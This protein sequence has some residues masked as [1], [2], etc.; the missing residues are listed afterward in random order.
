VTWTDPS[1]Q[2]A[3]ITSSTHQI[4]PA[5]DPQ[6]CSTPV[7]G[8]AEGPVSVTVPGPGTWTLTVWLTNTAGNSNPANTADT[9][10]TVPAP[11]GPEPE[12]SG[13]SDSNG[14]SPSTGG[15]NSGNPGTRTAGSGVTPK[16]T[17][18]VTETLHG[19]E[20][21]VHISGPTTGRVRVSYTARY[22]NKT[23]ASNA[24]T[25]ILKDGPL[26][27]I[28]KLGAQAATHATIRISAKLN[29]QPT[30]E[31]TL[32]PRIAPPHTKAKR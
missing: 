21:M 19:R 13:N 15:A 6:A 23:I 10:L 20:L 7:T 27:V 1:D 32:Q 11:A 28:F 25:V 24:K 2:V 3:P 17:I 12:S 31:S 16:P 30:V 8:P 5:N 14:G 18:H 22:H 9:T 29:H 26:T 4:C